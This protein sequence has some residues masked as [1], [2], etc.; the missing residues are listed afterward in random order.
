MG[1]A[2]EL[3][4]FFIDSL[5]LSWTSTALPYCHNQGP[6]NL[7]KNSRFRNSLKINKI[8]IADVRFI[9]TTSEL[10]SFHKIRPIL[11]GSFL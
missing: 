6:G 7:W 10:E 5:R 3:L 11:L 8:L 1:K 2:A 9:V 4:S